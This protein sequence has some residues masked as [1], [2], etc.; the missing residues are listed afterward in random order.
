MRAAAS[1]LKGDRK[2][3]PDGY[4]VPVCCMCVWRGAFKYYVDFCVYKYHV[5][6]RGY[7]HGVTHLYECHDSFTCVS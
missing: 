7:M 3:L 2:I 6:G 5:V 4:A 1:S